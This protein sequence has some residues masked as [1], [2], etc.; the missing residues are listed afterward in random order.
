[1]H[2]RGKCERDK[3]RDKSLDHVFSIDVIFLSLFAGTSLLSST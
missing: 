1:M 3:Y 2:V